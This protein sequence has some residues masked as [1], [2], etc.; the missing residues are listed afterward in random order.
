MLS[1]LVKKFGG[2]VTISRQDLEDL[3]PSEALSLIYDPVKKQ[4]ILKF[5]EMG[6]KK[7]NVIN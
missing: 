3:H 1:A 7:D 5:I 6:L 2:E 4:I